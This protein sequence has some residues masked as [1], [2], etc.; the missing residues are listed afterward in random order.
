MSTGHV[1]PLKSFLKLYFKQNIQNRLHQAVLN[2]HFV[3]ATWAIPGFANCGNRWAE[4]SRKPNISPMLCTLTRPPGSYKGCRQQQGHLC[5]ARDAPQRLIH[6]LPTKHSWCI[7]QKPVRQF[8]LV[9]VC[10]YQIC[11]I[12]AILYQH[13]LG[14]R[15]SFEHLGFRWATA[16]LGDVCWAPSS[17]IHH[18]R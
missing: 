1:F 9:W 14:T 4:H 17:S 5:I 8:N 2:S 18:T 12:P 13:P 10:Y 11:L 15:A 3:C 6:I 7:T 16:A